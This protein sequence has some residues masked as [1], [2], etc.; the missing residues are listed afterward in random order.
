[1][2]PEVGDYVSVDVAGEPLVAVRGEDRIRVLSRVCQHRWAPVVSGSGRTRI[3]SCPFHKWAYGLDGQLLATPFMEGAEDFDRS[4]CPL[5]EVRSEI[6]EDLGL[7]FITF[8]DTAPPIT[9]RLTDFRKTYSHWR[10]A[11]LKPIRVSSMVSAFNWKIQVETFM[12]CYH[13]I[14]AH[15]TTFEMDQPARLSSC[16][17][18]KVG[19]SVCHSPYRPDA[20]LDVRRSGLPIF[21]DLEGDELEACDYV[22]IF[23]NLLLAIRSD[24][25]SLLILF[26][27]SP[28]RTLA[29][30]VTLAHPTALA[31]PEAVE[32]SF[33]RR[34]DFMALAMQE[35]NEIN[36]LQQS[37]V[38]SRLAK[39]G[40]LSPLE[41]TVW[42]LANYVRARV[43]EVEGGQPRSLR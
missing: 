14:G 26:P 16:E 20:P 7:I 21:P 11:E 5:P 18:G 30:V 37:G 23:P 36:E 34:A 3:F 12:E 17:D 10:L 33:A 2:L 19:W 8:S 25:V 39:P 27:E 13:H 1:M 43:A 9:D 42:D 40:R 35:D 41:T 28:K 29:Q 15:P 31:D 4:R 6:D 38:V 24:M 22:N 32:E